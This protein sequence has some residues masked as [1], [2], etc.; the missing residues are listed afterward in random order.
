M[1]NLESDG[2]APLA[3]AMRQLAFRCAEEGWHAQARTLLNE[4]QQVA[5]RCSSKIRQ[6]DLT[7]CESQRCPYSIEVTQFGRFQIARNGALLGPYQ[8]K[9]AIWVLRYLLSMIRRVAHKGEIA[10]LLWPNSPS[11][12]AY[13]SL[14]VAVAALR[15][16]LDLGD[17]Q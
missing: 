1:P 13:H 12:R 15:M 9:R 11:E 14:H 10:T 17:E 5:S 2:T 3:L 7:E 6:Y 16:Y 8:S 4:A